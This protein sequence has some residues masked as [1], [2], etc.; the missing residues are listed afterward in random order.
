M[1]V[2][3]ILIPTFLLFVAL[4]CLHIFFKFAYICQHLTLF[5]FI[6]HVFIL[7]L[8]CGK[9]LHCGLQ[10]CMDNLW[11]VGNFPKIST[12]T[13]MVRNLFYFLFVLYFFLNF[14]LKIFNLQTTAVVHVTRATWLNFC[15]KPYVSLSLS[16]KNK[17]KKKPNK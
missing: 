9:Y 3:A 2:I 7:K 14:G 5:L 13:L 4:N 12:S 10:I 8:V 16:K 11:S 6:F 15:P 1:F 17:N